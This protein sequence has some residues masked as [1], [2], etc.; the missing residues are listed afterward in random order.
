M[1]HRYR[2][3]LDEQLRLEI[4]L[5]QTQQHTNESIIDMLESE[6]QQVGTLI[7]IDVGG[8]LT[9]TRS[10]LATLT[11]SPLMSE[12]VGLIDKTDDCLD[13]ILRDSPAPRSGNKR[14]PNYPCRTGPATQSDQF[15]SFIVHL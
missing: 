1:A 2:K 6:R 8:R 4:S 9:Q 14:T 11:P 7:L 5:A 13:Q 12:A 10:L 15:G 3:S